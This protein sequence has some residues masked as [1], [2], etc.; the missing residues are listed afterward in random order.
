MGKRKDRSGKKDPKAARAS[1]VEHEASFLLS[2]PWEALVLTLLPLLLYL[3]SVNFGFVL[4]DKIVI[5]NNQFV[6]EGING[7]GKILSTESF[8]GY[9]GE[10]PSVVAG[11]RYR[12]LSLVSF[13]VEHELYGLNPAMSHLIN[14]LLYSATCL[15]LFR[16]LSIIARGEKDRPWYFRLP[17][18][19]TLL[20]ALHPLHSEVVANIKGRDEILTLL[21][22]LATLLLIFRY[23]RNKNPLF[24][25]LGGL[26]FLLALLAK[27]NAIT[28]LAVAPLTIF[29][30]TNAKARTISIAMTPLVISTAIYLFMRYQV[31]D[32]LLLGGSEE[33]TELM[34]NPFVEASIGEK[35]GT[36]FYTWGLYLKLL[37]FPHPLTH[38]YYPYQVPLVGLADLRAIIP[39]ILYLAMASFAVLKFRKGNIASWSILFFLATFSLVS[40]LL[41]PI[42]TFMNERFMYIPSIGFCLALAWILTRKMPTWLDAKPSLSR[43]VPVGITAVFVLGF[44]LKTLARIP[45]WEDDMS[46][47]RAGAAVSTGSARINCFMGY[48]LY[49]A[50]LEE[51]DN[52]RKQEILDEATFY[53]DRSLKIYP[54][55]RDALN[56]YAGVLSSRYLLDGDIDALL[57]GFFQILTKNKPP[58]IDNFLIWLNYQ[59]R[60]HEELANFYF[61]TGYEYYF[62]KLENDA[63]AKKYLDFGYRVAPDNVLILEALGNFWLA[64]ENGPQTLKTRRDAYTA[65][66]YAEEGI[67]LDP[68]HGRFY[69]IAAEAHERL[70]DPAKAD[71]MR[72]QAS[73]MN[74]P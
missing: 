66:K 32:F 4:D 58:Q 47:N 71:L 33:V 24:L 72:Q 55:Y 38:D 15:M 56:V 2:H 11:S 39:M 50:S 1:A 69:E 60:H 25:A 44:S 27:E 37:I 31:V 70:G 29:M 8:I 42:G 35:Y 54:S 5:Q 17:F 20:F 9:I 22:S 16:F 30:F 18:V 53:L 10:R 36:I 73:R 59:D 3:S 74:S 23:I 41:F 45:D 46:L 43:A 49:E 68:A 12:P 26:A 40:N 7:I 62:Q 57:E 63:E 48:S 61:E 6:Q 13:S 21:F 34:N 67:G 64:R 19:A 52:A 65:L 28:F 51:Q 14:V